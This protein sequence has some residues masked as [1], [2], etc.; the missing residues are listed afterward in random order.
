[1]GS[2]PAESP[3]VSVRLVCLGPSGRAN[4]LHLLRTDPSETTPK[5]PFCLPWEDGWDV[6]PVGPGH[7]G[8]ILGEWELGH[9]AMAL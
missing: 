7:R 2:C 5:T 4:L 8:Q 9:L 3:A 6:F 1:M